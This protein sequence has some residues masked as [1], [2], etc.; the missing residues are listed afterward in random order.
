[1]ITEPDWGTNQYHTSTYTLGSNG[2]VQSCDEY[3]WQYNSDGYLINVNE[4]GEG[5]D[6]KY[7]YKDG[8]IVSS[9]EYESITMS[10]I[11][12]IGGLYIT[13]EWGLHGVRH[14]YCG[15]F[16]KPSKYLPKSAFSDGDKVDFSYKLDKDGY[17]T[18]ITRKWS[19]GETW[20][21]YYSYEPIP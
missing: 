12:N 20:T 3:T 13:E 1:M 8:N 5:Y 15:L 19:Y 2:Q 18:E 16:G 7:T 4:G 11:P 14:R 9:P 21:A 10:D 6:L 17:V